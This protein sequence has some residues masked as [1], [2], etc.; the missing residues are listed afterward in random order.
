[1]E[2]LATAERWSGVQELTVL[3][4]AKGCMPNPA[5][6][7]AKLDMGNSGAGNPLHNR[8]LLI[9]ELPQTDNF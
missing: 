6:S 4:G 2:L 7:L 5:V 9:M 8:S 1:M 3:D